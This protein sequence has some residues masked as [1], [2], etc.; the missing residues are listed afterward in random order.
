MPVQM[1]LI[2][3]TWGQ[4]GVTP[5][6]CNHLHNYH[7]NTQN[8]LKLQNA[9]SHCHEAS[10]TQHLG[11]WQLDVI[12][13]I[14]LGSTTR[15]ISG[16]RR[17]VNEICALLGYYSTYSGNSLPKFS[18]NLSVP[19]SRVKE[20]KEKGFLTPENRTYITVT[21]PYTFGTHFAEHP[22]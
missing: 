12:S 4:T 19:S 11:P 15:V 1:P 10:G 17:E 9:M 13:P 18:G 20:S 7:C 6:V 5:A 21:L 16:F 3:A 14:L 2:T 22:V 8:I